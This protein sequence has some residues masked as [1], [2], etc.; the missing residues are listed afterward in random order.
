M[1]YTEYTAPSAKVSHAP[2]TVGTIDATNR[3]TIWAGGEI[4]SSG[5]GPHTGIQNSTAVMTR[6]V[7]MP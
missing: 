5:N 3:Y 4:R 7:C 1:S 2:G 6:A